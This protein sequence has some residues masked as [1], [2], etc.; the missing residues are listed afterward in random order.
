MQSVPKIVDFKTQPTI[1]FDC[2]NSW[3]FLLVNPVHKFPRTSSFVGDL[4]NLEVK[5]C[6]FCVLDHFLELFPVL[7]TLGYPVLIKVSTAIYVPS[8]L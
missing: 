1:I 8:T 4:L 7:Y 6:A 3:E 2:F 5:E